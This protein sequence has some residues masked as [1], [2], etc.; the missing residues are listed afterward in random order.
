MNPTSIHEDVGSIPGLAQWVKG[1]GI[2]ISCGVGLSCGLDPVLLWL[3]HRLAATALILPLAW[4]P[5]YTVGVALERPPK[6]VGGIEEFP[7]DLV[8]KDWHCH[9]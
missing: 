1:S 2:A 8:V 7:G 6:K 5:P 9:G 3:L 4:E